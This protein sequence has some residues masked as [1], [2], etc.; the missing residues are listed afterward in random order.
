MG[1]QPVT[2]QIA[3]D[4]DSHLLLAAGRHG[5]CQPAWRGRLPAQAIRSLETPRSS[6]VSSGALAFA[7]SDC[8]GSI[9]W[10]RSGKIFLLVGC[11]VVLVI[12]PAEN[13]GNRQHL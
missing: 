11:A 12:G 1:S 5:E 4:L 2:L 3:P 10:I 8:I 13:S 7:T 9:S 6:Q